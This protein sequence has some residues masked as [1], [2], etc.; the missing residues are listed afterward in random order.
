MTRDVAKLFFTKIYHAAL[1]VLICVKYDHLADK[2]KFVLPPP[3]LHN[4]MESLLEEVDSAHNEVC[5]RRN[6]KNITDWKELGMDFDGT[7]V[8]RI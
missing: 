8:G 5:N 3:C 2:S 4:R 6:W 1:H 7:D